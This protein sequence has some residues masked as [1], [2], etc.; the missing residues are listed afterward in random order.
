MHG[1]LDERAR[2]LA[3]GHVVPLRQA[4]VWKAAKTWTRACENNP[5]MQYLR[6]SHKQSGLEKAIDRVVMTALM[7]LLRKRRIALTVD[8]STA[9]VFAAPPSV[10]SEPTGPLDRTSTVIIR[11][12]TSILQRKIVSSEQRKRNQELE[13]K[14]KKAIENSLGDRVK[15]MVTIMILATDPDSRGRGYGGS[16]LDSVTSLADVMGQTSW[17]TSSNVA[18]TEFYRIHGFKTIADIV[19]GDDNPEWHEQPVV[20][21]LMVRAPRGRIA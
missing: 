18:N 14:T 17:L 20:V 5:E 1:V 11:I 2:L 12:L 16:L 21:K 13:D 8:D 7:S 10:V 6:M 19:L 9:F 3:P 4:H 15:D